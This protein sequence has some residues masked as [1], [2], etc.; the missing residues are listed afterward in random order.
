MAAR[1]CRSKY[2]W[3]CSIPPLCGGLRSSIS[4]GGGRAGLRAL[5]LRVEPR[6]AGG[7]DAGAVAASIAECVRQ[8]LRVAADVE[9][10]A[11]N[12]LPRFAFKA[13]RGVDE[14]STTKTTQ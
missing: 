9:L 7:T 11:P 5:P 3:R 14:R 10:L 1:S 12:A 2:C 6:A 13:A 4:W 8:L